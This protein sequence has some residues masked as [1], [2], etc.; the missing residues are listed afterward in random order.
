MD[1]VEDG[2]KYLSR[3]GEVYHID[4]GKRKDKR[5]LKVVI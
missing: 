4:I 3:L 1:V 5:L 2:S